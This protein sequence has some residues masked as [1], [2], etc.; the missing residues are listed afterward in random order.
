MKKYSWFL[1]ILLFVVSVFA[2][3]QLL[4]LRTA[5]KEISS[6]KHE[7][8]LWIKAYEE[9]KSIIG[10][11]QSQIDVEVDTR[12]NLEKKIASLEEKNVA[13]LTELDK[14]K[15]QTVSLDD[16]SLA[17]RIG[18]FIGASEISVIKLDK[19]SFSLTRIG[20]ER[21]LSLF[22][23]SKAYFSLANQRLE[24]IRLYEEKEQSYLKTIEL[25]DVEI[26]VYKRTVE[27][28]NKV[29]V[30]YDKTVAG[31]LRKNSKNKL[32]WF[33]RGVLLG[34]GVVL[35]FSLIR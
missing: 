7:V 5:Y 26:G 20:G 17:G 30:D 31:L 21:T 25:K 16:V 8:E 34:S 1:T 24:Q 28:A 35:F 19:Y 10:E 27:E 4:Y 29:I 3:T 14:Y 23:D 22:Y 15:Q 11:L 9:S 13:L 6:A 32:A 2:F 12:K 33:G 18:D